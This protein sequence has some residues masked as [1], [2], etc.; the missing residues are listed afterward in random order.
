MFWN[1]MIDNYGN[2]SN[3]KI[4]HHTLPMVVPIYC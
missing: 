1:R 4:I 2:L 3:S